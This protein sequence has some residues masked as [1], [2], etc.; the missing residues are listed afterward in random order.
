M[1]SGISIWLASNAYRLGGTLGYPLLRP[2][3]ARRARRGK[4]DK[5]RIDERFGRTSRERPAGPLV[6]IHAAS[7]GETLAV[8]S[9]IQNIRNFGINILLTTGTVT[10]ARL[11]EERFSD[12]VIHQYVPLDVVP[13]V[14]RFLDHWRPDLA[15]NV[16]TEV[17]PVTIAELSRR[18]IAQII[19]N[20][21]ISD[22]SFARWLK[23]RDLARTLFSRFS[24]VM[25]QTD[26]DSER[27][28]DLGAMHVSVA[29]NLKVDRTAPPADDDALRTLAA[30]IG[31]RA[32]W[33]AISTFDGEEK[34]AADVHAALKA[35]HADLLTIIVPR[36]PDRA[37]V[38]AGLF[39]AKGLSVKR[40]SLGE[41]PD[42]QTDIYLGDTIGEMGLYLRLTEIAFVGRSM[43]ARGGQN[44]LEP[45][46]LG[47]AIL[48][49]QH[50][51]NFRDTYRQLR[52][53]GAVRTVDG[54]EALLQSVDLLLSDD[55]SRAQM[56]EAGY[57]GVRDMRGALVRTMKGLE[58]YLA[59]LILEARFCARPREVT[60]K[61]GRTVKSERL[62]E[63]N[64]RKALR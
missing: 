39:A 12:T 27:F 57:A 51:D 41:L 30:A 5:A 22:R 17:W 48:T 20:G 10:S 60:E 35:R 18:K 37:D 42:E 23:R 58:R 31:E 64:L 54:P 36:H 3:L 16:E 1:R 61:Q 7:V 14:T 4:E 46:M 55:K 32:V 9:L 26:L 8:A 2:L 33:A 52:Q 15:I 38:L 59:P 56:I 6:W 43:T 53:K 49:G 28:A 62:P 50:V 21:R 34:Y 25:A 19:V 47:A 29:G 13:A 44:P 45:A 40:R 63:Q 11:V 24:L